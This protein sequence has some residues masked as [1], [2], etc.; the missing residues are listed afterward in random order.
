MLA[1]IVG[2]LLGICFSIWQLFESRF[3]SMF[4]KFG[5]TSWALFSHRFCIDFIMDCGLTFDVFVDTFS[6]RVRK[7]QSIK[8]TLFSKWIWMFLHIRENIDL[9]YFHDMCWYLFGHW[10]L[11]TLAIDFGFVLEPLLC[12]FCVPPRSFIW[13]RGW[14]LFRFYATSHPK[15]YPKTSAAGPAASGLPPRF[16]CTLLTVVVPT[17]VIPRVFL[18]QNSP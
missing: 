2:C 4:H 3:W 11:I 8:T 7:L 10:F 6:V 17:S 14:Y 12:F 18:F 5:I 1:L 16:S 13:F 9:D 15:M